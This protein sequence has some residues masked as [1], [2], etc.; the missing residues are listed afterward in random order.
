M[1]Y[2]F[3]GFCVCVHVCQ[4][5]TFESLAVGSSYLYIRCISRHYGSSLYM[6]VIGSRSRLQE[7][8]TSKYILWSPLLWFY[9]AIRFTRSVGFLG[10]ADPVVWSPSLSRDVKWPRL[11]K[12]HTF[13]GCNTISF[14]S[15]DIGSLFSHILYISR[16]Y[17]PSS[18]MNVIGSR[19]SFA[20]G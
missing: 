5:I 20:G 7:P 6:K 3:G 10:M 13:A 2:N 1:V 17:K 19:C 8:K 18:L 14:I 12:M 9:R 15:L 11:T 16:E 4:M